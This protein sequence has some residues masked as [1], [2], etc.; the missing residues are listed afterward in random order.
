MENAPG[1]TAE[2]VGLVAKWADRDAT[3]DAGTSSQVR[4]S[5]SRNKR[6]TLSLDQSRGCEWAD[7]LRVHAN[8]RFAGA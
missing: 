8:G 4:L 5:D 1:Q 6:V 3:A 2:R 7:T